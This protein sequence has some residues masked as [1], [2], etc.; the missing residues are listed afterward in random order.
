MYRRWKS[1]IVCI[2]ITKERSLIRLESYEKETKLWE[3][4]SYERKC[5]EGDMKR[6]NGSV[7][8]FIWKAME[9]SQNPHGKLRKVSNYEM[10]AK[11]RLRRHTSPV[12]IQTR[13]DPLFPW[14]CLSSKVTNGAVLQ[15][16]LLKP[17]P[18]V[19][20][21]VAGLTGADPKNFSKGGGGW[22]E[23]F[24]KKNVC[25]YTYQRVYT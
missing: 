9:M 10:Y 16:R 13:I 17:G 1:Q 4:H 6:H 24:W 25:W 3:C 20:A 21:G 5:H 22:G 11:G 23:K 12:D 15:M 8:E 14:H 19:T 2:W 18:R 7:T